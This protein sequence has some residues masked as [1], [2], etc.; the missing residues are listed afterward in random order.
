MNQRIKKK[1]FICFIKNAAFHLAARQKNTK[2]FTIFL[3]KIKKQEAQQL[4]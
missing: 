1:P 2:I 4:K 3:K